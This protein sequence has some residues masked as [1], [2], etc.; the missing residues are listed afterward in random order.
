MKAT[1]RSRRQVS[2]DHFLLRLK[3]EKKIRAKPGQFV[4]LPPLASGC[5]R[6]PFSV[7][8]ISRDGTIVS[9]LVKAVGPNTRAYSRL[10]L[11]DGINISGPK[12]NPIPLDSEVER[13]ILV[14]GG[15]GG[16]ALILL[17][18]DLRE[19]GKTVTFLLGVKKPS[20]IFG[21]EELGAIG[22]HL[23]TITQEG[24]ENG[25]KTGK[26]TDLLK[27]ALAGDEGKSTVIACGPT[28]MLKEIATMTA[29]SRNSCLVLLEERMACGV[30]SCKGCA[31]FC[32]DKTTKHV[33]EDGPAFDAS[34]IDWE[35]IMR[36]YE[37]APLVKSSEG[38]AKNPLETTLLG[39]GG[40]TLTLATPIMNGSGSLATKAIKKGDVNI[41]RTGALITKVVTLEGLSGNEGHRVCEI[42]AGMLNSIGMENPGI[43]RFLK[44]DL[45][46]W[47]SFGL[48]VIVNIAGSKI[49]EYG[50]ISCRLA[51]TGIRGME[52][53]ISCPNKEGSGIAFGVD[54][55]Q[56]FRV[57]EAVRKW[58]KDKFVIVKLT[59]TAGIYIVDVARAAKEAG[60]DAI[61]AINTLPGMAIDVYARRPKIG[62]GFGGMSGPAIH[63]HAVKIVYDLAQ[64]D[65][66]IPIIGIGGNDDGESAMEMI[67][68]GASVVEVGTGLFGNGNAMSDMHDFFLKMVSYH[69]VSHIRDL[70]GQGGV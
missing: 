13:Y 68:A 37:V 39:Q 53:N 17:A 61:A 14:G 24:E 56:A 50:E 21:V 16:A 12:G 19:K 67:L 63:A 38:R 58:A 57:V 48:P 20:Q 42:P 44:E 34:E 36:P 69:Q 7:Y 49:Y 45:P 54:P 47:S 40:R 25:T 33:C 28:A 51:D 2:E 60:A 55:T 22:C 70:V 35:R 29:E 6:R 43:E 65:L 1:V 59:P 15:I 31:V 32:K 18:K 27:E 64:A 11:H 66:G 52:V 62:R 26:A 3:L 8:D 41:A 46:E 9:I 23:Q 4:T 5:W 30:G 10:K